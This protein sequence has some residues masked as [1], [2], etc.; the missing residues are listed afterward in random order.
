[1]FWCYILIMTIIRLQNF[2]R[3]FI[4]QTSAHYW[5]LYTRF[6]LFLIILLFWDEKIIFLPLKIISSSPPKKRNYRTKTR[7]IS[8]SVKS[9]FSKKATKIWKTLPLVSTLLSKNSYFVKTGGRFFQ[10]FG[11]LLMS[12]HHLEQPE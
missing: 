1:M 9:S 3:R 12:S 11:L 5:Y 2:I 8:I 7:P 10:I 6:C 4:A